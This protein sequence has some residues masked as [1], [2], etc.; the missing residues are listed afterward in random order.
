MAARPPRAA[1]GEVVPH[2]ADSLVIVVASTL[3]ERLR[4]VGRLGHVGPLLIV[5][6]PQEA[7][8][9]LHRRSPPAEPDPVSESTLSVGAGLELHPERQV[10]SYAGTEVG[11]TPLEFALIAALTREPG[12]VKTFAVLSRQV[13]GTPH[14]GDVAAVHAVVKRLRRKLSGLR[15]PLRVE[16]IRG[17]G[18][19]AVPTRPLQTVREPSR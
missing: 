12:R 10:A 6:S 5:S 9:V 7:Q 15:A 16:A 1:A 18:F 19:R 17:I 3:E 13:W 8:E 2:V 14:L 4:L 11:L